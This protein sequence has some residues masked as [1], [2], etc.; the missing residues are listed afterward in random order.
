MV[1]FRSY[2]WLQVYKLH[3]GGVWETIC[4]VRNF[5]LGYRIVLSDYSQLL[6]VYIY[7]LLHFILLSLR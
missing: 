6:S 1:V 3:F 7:L 2:L 4:G 5:N